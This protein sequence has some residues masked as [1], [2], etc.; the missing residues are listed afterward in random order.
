MVLALTIS[1]DT[2]WAQVS[3]VLAPAT[4]ALLAIF[5]GAVGYYFRGKD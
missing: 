5:S 1:D 3:S 2:R 4:T